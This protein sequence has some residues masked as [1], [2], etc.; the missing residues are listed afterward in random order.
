MWQRR[1]EA[2]QA[3]ARE[4]YSRAKVA[5]KAAREAN[6]LAESVREEV[7]CRLAEPP[8]ADGCEKIRFHHRAEADEFAEALSS[9]TKQ[10]RDAYRVYQ[11]N[12]CPRSPVTMHRYWHVGHPNRAAA[13]KAAGIQKRRRE[14]ASAYQE[15][16]QLQQRVDPTVLARLRRIGRA[17]DSS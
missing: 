3:Q 6:Q 9:D 1:C 12:V 15:G 13:I 11:C 10:G 17:S 4:A 7:L 8:Q 16:R 14:S 2:A 5:E